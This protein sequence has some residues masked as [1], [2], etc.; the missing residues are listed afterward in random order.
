[1][2]GVPLRWAIVGVGVA[3]RARA[4]AIVADPRSRLVAVH[5]GRFA[6]QLDVR[7]LPFDDAVAAADAVAICSPTPLHPDQVRAVLEAGKHAVV[8]FPVAGSHHEAAEL[9]QL[10]ADVGRVLHVEHIELLDAAQITLRAQARP[11]LIRHIDVQFE[12]P[13]SETA[14]AATLALG[15]VAR[16]H[17]LTHL[18]GPVRTIDAVD[19]EP[20][21]LAASLTLDGGV[22]A[23]LRFRESPGLPRRTRLEVDGTIAVW[24]IEDRILFRN[25]Q[26]Q[27]LLAT[28]PLFE[29]D[30]R[31][32]VARILDGKRP[33]VEDARI[34]HV[35][36]VVD[37]LGQGRLGPL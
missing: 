31:A 12:R 33:Y 28:R 13:G 35:L 2:S 15:N 26:P 10:A 30:H 8:E 5:R 25:R 20:G 16:L 32:A 19:A 29:Q 21:Q 27:T 17:R 18:A 37:A 11:E 4:R 1:M 6:D 7:A 34:L 23:T 14:D 22:T 9:M 24:C 36:G 3:G